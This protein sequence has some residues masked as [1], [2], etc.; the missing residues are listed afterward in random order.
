MDWNLDA[1]QDWLTTAEARL[2]RIAEKNSR[3]RHT[4]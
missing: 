3:Y 4:V 1:Y 2:T